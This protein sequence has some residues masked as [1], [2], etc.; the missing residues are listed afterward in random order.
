[1][2]AIHISHDTL[3]Y[4][5]LVNFKGTPFIES[6]GKVNLK[7]GMLIPDTENS[8]IVMALGEQIATIRNSAEFPDNTTHVVFDSDWFPLDM[9]KVDSVLV[10]RD[11][12]KFLKWR[13][14]EMLESAISQYSIVHQ[15]LV[16]PP[17][18]GVDFLSIAV[19]VSFNT[20]VEK[21]FAQSELSVKKVTM[22]IQSIGDILTASGQM[23]TAGGIQVV[24]DNR[25]NTIACHIFQH[26]EICGIFQAN[27]NWD[28]KVTLDYVRGD[29][30][31]IEQVR[32]AIERAIKGKRDPDTV[33]TN[34]LYYSSTGDPAVL[35]NLKKYEDS[36]SPL[37]LG[38]HFNFRDP[39]FENIDEYAVV[40]GALSGEIQERFNED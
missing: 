33:I 26:Q 12:E 18:N 1:M 9:A 34:L 32:E 25:D 27:L 38:Q 14:T 10:D 24:M 5:Q 31:L 35:A 17:E 39:D 15:E 3:K 23:D 2:L 19:P 40:L 11:R 37:D 8:A 4:A 20:W 7:E 28:Y 29:A 30:V 13:M 22:D 6:L 16:G 21:V 36:C